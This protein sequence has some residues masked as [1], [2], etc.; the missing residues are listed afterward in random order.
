MVR[1]LIGVFLFIEL[2]FEQG[3][4][5]QQLLKQSRIRAFRTIFSRAL[6]KAVRSPL[7]IFEWNSAEVNILLPTPSPIFMTPFIYRIPKVGPSVINAYV[8]ISFG[9]WWEGLR[10]AA[11]CMMFFLT[12]SER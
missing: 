7:F 11:C 6:M 10:P 8:G 9:S 2:V 12:Y 5:Q 1:L 4:Q 3:Q